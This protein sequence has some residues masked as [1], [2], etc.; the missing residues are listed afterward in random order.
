MRTR[1]LSERHL[2]DRALEERVR[3]SLRGEVRDL[4]RVA[5]AGD[6]LVYHGQTEMARLW[7]L[8]RARRRPVRVI[9]REGIIRLQIAD[10]DAMVSSKSRSP[11]DLRDF[12]EGH[13]DYGDA[14]RALPPLFVCFRGRV[15]DFTG[16]TAAD[17]V[18]GLL[19]VEIDHL[20]PS[21][22]VVGLISRL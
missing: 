1:D 9:D 15:L 3:Q 21:E 8:R 14:G 16:L 2:D 5:S 13:T 12:L 20:E 19:G 10:G 11:G 17:Q 6:L 18:Q 7:G 22:T 4:S